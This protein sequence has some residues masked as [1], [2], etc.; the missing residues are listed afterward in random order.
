LR[1]AADW[2]LGWLALGEF[3][4]LWLLAR[5]ASREGLRLRD[6]YNRYSLVGAA[7]SDDFWSPWWWLVP[8]VIY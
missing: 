3:F 1:Q 7:I 8:W 5:L 6:L 2:W 4:N